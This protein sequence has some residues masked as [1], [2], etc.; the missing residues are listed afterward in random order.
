[1]ACV[2]CVLI[3]YKD[4]M[5]YWIRAHP[6]GLILLLAKSLQSCLTLCDP[7]DCSPP[8]SSVHGI[9]QQEYWSV[10]PGPPPED[11]PDPGI[12]PGSLMSPAL[13]G[14]FFTTS[15]TWEA[16]FIIITS[17]KALSPNTVTFWGA[18]GLNFSKWIWGGH[19]SVHNIGK[20]AILDLSEYRSRKRGSTSQ[21]FPMYDLDY[22]HGNARRSRRRCLSLQ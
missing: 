16:Y 6:H 9:L 20:Y 22:S 15:T 12:D 2:V 14:R 19:S 13:A 10:L 5:S 17:L 4:T 18:G 7:V 11:L 21:Y 8:A 1:M 3:S